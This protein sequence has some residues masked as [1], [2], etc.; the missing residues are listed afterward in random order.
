MALN[1]FRQVLVSNRRCL[2]NMGFI[3]R[4]SKIYEPDYLETGKS[5]I[6]VHPY[7]DLEITGYSYP[8][9]ETFQSY[10]YKLSRFLNFD[11]IDSY[12]FPNKEL[13]QT[14]RQH[15]VHYC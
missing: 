2:V 12:A 4:Y 7:L 15:S 8:T 1:I 9:L 14:Y 13:K 6:P 5:K 3:Q 11:I 10:V